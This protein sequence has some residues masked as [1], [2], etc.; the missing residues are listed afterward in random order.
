MLGHID[1]DV[2][3]GQV[4]ES[5]VDMS[6]GRYVGARLRSET[7]K[8]GNIQIALDMLEAA[9]GISAGASNVNGVP[10]AFD[11]KVPS[12]DI[13]D[14]NAEV[15][16][17]PDMHVDGDPS[18]IREKRKPT[19]WEKRVAL[20]QQKL[21][22]AENLNKAAGLN[23]DTQKKNI[24]A[25]QLEKVASD[26]QLATTRVQATNAPEIAA[27]K[28]IVQD[29]AGDVIPKSKDTLAAQIGLDLNEAPEQQP[30]ES[31]MQYQKRKMAWIKAAKKA[32][33]AIGTYVG[34]KLALPAPVAA[35]DLIVDAI[36][37][38]LTPSPAG[39]KRI[40]DISSDELM[41]RI[42]DDSVA[43]KA[44]KITIQPGNYDSPEISDPEQR[45]QAAREEATSRY[46]D[47]M[48]SF[49]R[50]RD[51]AE[52]EAKQQ[53]LPEDTFKQRPK[54]SFLQKYEAYFNE[55]TADEYVN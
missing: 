33:I 37:F 21:N 54:S 25:A 28:A 30:D 32:G 11:I 2:P 6:Q 31:N 13:I 39:I 1:D 46:V 50:R 53:G 55:G 12:L 41:T 20:S 38:T 15:I 36:D 43:A 3:V 16:D 22:Y 24:E 29:A 5:M 10:E 8:K 19:K 49:I 9:V 47:D 4:V 51:T 40:E 14:N 35:G 52:R 27:N 44:S 48:D 34:T 26:E 45:R 7:G 18:V 42:Q 23:V 17:F